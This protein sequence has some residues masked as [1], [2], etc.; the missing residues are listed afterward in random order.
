MN[1]A[2]TL[3]PTFIN[4]L[5]IKMLLRN[6]V[7][8]RVFAEL[9]YTTR[10]EMSYGNCKPNVLAKTVTVMTAVCRSYDSR[11]SYGDSAPFG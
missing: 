10:N 1:V 2:K 3:H 9:A 6:N 4:H 7:G 5:N 11:L 8:C